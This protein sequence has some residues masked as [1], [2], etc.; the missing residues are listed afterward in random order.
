MARKKEDVYKTHCRTKQGTYIFTYTH[1]KTKG[2]A[3]NLSF[4]GGQD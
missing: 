2:G 1:T 3:R 4:G